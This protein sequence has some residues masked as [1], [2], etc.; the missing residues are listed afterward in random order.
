MV[1]LDWLWDFLYRNNIYRGWHLGKRLTILGERGT[2]K[3]H[4]FHFLEY[5]H[6]PRSYI[7]TPTI[8]K[9]ANFPTR[10]KSS[11]G[12]NIAFEHNVDVSGDETY[13]NVWRDCCESADWI[14]YLLRADKVMAGD[15]T[16]LKRIESDVAYI[17][18]CLLERKARPEKIAIVGTHCDLDPKYKHDRASEYQD[19]FRRTRCIE[20][21]DCFFGGKPRPV[22]LAGSLRD[23][24]GAQRLLN[25]IGKA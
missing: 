2:G 7:P 20:R 16:S 18:E 8:D 25:E 19:S 1:D 22:I 14:I 3:T 6:L 24:A 17:S 10:M 4:L 13:L 15:V 21:L 11:S 12:E 5:G 23:D 9:K